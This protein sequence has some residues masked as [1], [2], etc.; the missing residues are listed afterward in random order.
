M[1]NRNWRDAFEDLLSLETRGSMIDPNNRA[2]E[3]KTA[4]DI[5]AEQAR[6]RIPKLNQLIQRSATDISMM[7]QVLAKFKE[8]GAQ[9]GVEII[10]KNLKHPQQLVQR[11]IAF[12]ESI[13]SNVHHPP[14]MTKISSAY[15]KTRAHWA[16][17]LITSGACHGWR[18]GVQN[19]AD[20]ALWDFIR[21]DQDHKPRGGGCS[22]TEKELTDLFERNKGLY[23]G[24]PAPSP[25]DQDTINATPEEREQAVNVSTPEL[26][27][28]V[29]EHYR[30]WIDRPKATILKL[31]THCLAS[32]DGP[33]RVKV[34]TQ[35]TD[36]REEVKE[37]VGDTSAVL[38]KVE[39]ALSDIADRNNGLEQD[40]YEDTQEIKDLRAAVLAVN[41]VGDDVN[42]EVKVEQG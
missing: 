10:E 33:M 1:P 30:R 39:R 34:Y 16:A 15:F 41:D 5:R 27:S 29:G 36:K 20:G 7:N 3:R 25:F 22:I 21:I 37:I 28:A 24:S 38:R 19:S 14:P 12:T 13:I 2:A 17:S 11:R 26:H 6:E 4:E 18:S 9:T 35:Y 31:G 42:S 23:P 40:S 8:R 32:E